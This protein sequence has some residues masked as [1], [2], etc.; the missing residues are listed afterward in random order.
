MNPQ[1]KITILMVEDNLPF[2][3]GMSAL[4]GSSPDLHV[5]AETG[6]GSLALETY[7]SFMPDVVMMD[8]H[9]PGMDGV[10]ATESIRKE[11]TDARIIILTTFDLDEDIF[12]AI[13][14]GAKSYLLKDVDEEE[15]AATI[16]SVHAGEQILPHKVAKLLGNKQQ[17]SVVS[18]KEREALRLLVQHR[19][20]KEIAAALLINEDA[21]NNYMIRLF[22][23]SKVRNSSEFDHQ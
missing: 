19:S 23:K 7:R 1:R 2:R 15:L 12:R 13:Q 10:E 6:D 8:L 3:K 22:G 14:A 17:P 4:I 16:R 20:N 18:D 21:V 5:I 9:L 11:F